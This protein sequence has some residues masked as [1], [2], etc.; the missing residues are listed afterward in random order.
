[1]FR[2]KSVIHRDH[3]A[4]GPG[5]QVAAYP[6]MRVQAAQHEA[7]AVQEHQQRERSRPQGLIDAQPKV[8]ARP[9][10][11][12]FGHA[13]DDGGRCHDRDTRLVLRTRIRHRQRVRRRHPGPFVEQRLDL[14]IDRHGS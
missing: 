7:A 9:A 8:P 3:H 11:A 12:A 1:M 13:A 2:R 6:V 4:P 5:T 10:D 14:R